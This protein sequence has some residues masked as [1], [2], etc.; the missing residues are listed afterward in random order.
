[1][2]HG[3]MAGAAACEQRISAAPTPKVVPTLSSHTDHLRSMISGAHELAG[4]MEHALDR[5]L[6]AEPEKDG[7]AKCAEGPSNFERELYSIGESTNTL[8]ARL[9]RI[10]QRLDS[11]V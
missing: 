2:N 10:A 11:A 9:H 1:M 6:G 5:L 3:R 4:R 7:S 8:L